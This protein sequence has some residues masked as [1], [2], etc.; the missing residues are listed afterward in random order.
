MEHARVPTVDW[1]LESDISSLPPAFDVLE[2]RAFG[3]YATVCRARRRDD[4]LQREVAVKTLNATLVDNARALMRTRDEARMMA[5]LS[6]PHI[7]KIEALID[8]DRRPVLVMEW[9]SGASVGELLTEHR[10]LSLIHI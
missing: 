4:P 9:V 3:A 8:Y 1:G 6:H 10:K 7:V 2:I 5:R